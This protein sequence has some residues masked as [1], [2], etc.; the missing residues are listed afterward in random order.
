MW[1]YRAHGF[2]KMIAARAT[3]SNSPLRP[4][5][6]GEGYFDEKS[7]HFPRLI[8]YL[9][10]LRTPKLLTPPVFEPDRPLPFSQQNS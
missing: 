6:W 9:L 7:H 2:R 5:S 3:T 10:N 8:Y 1:E 4:V